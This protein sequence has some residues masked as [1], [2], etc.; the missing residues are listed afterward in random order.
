MARPVVER[1][2]GKKE[3]VGLF[4]LFSRTRG[5]QTLGKCCELLKQTSVPA[6][7][8]NTQVL[9]IEDTVPVFHSHFLQ[10]QY[11]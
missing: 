9:R 7:V 2:P 1:V 5:K 4:E 3:A 10:Q 8:R 6:A 11:L